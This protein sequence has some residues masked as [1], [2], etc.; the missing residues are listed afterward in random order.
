MKFVL[1]PLIHLIALLICS[2]GWSQ[3]YE[4]YKHLLDTTIHSTHLG[5]GKP[6]TITVPFEWQKNMDGDFPLLIIFDRQNKRSHQYLLNTIDYLTSNEQIPS[7]II[8]GI[9]SSSHRHTETSYKASNPNGKGDENQQFIFDELIP[10][11]KKTYHASSFT[12]LMGHSRYGYFTTSLM[13]NRLMEVNA[14]VSLSPFFTQP[15]IDLVDELT[16]TVNKTKLASYKYYRYGI[17][18]DYPEDFKAVTT[19]LESLSKTNAFFDHKGWLF[20]EADHNVTPGLTVSRALYEIFEFWSKQQRVFIDD[21]NSDLST[22]AELS[23]KVRAHYGHE[24][25]FSIGMLNGKGW[26][27]YSDGNYEK[28]IES[29]ELLLQ[30][31]PTFSQAYLSIIQAQK[32]LELNVQA[33]VNTFKES[34]KNSDIYTEKQKQEFLDAIN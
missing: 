23:E 7:F 22:V 13:I 17:G 27:F 31:Y 16:E 20:P 29:W 2:N 25:K 19:A 6:I 12:M 33:T 14:V 11:L 8:V 10:I 4:R 30:H 34:L 1:T 15:N 3:K 24:L 26:Q 28:A 32:K 9:E 5:Y 18:K 21:K